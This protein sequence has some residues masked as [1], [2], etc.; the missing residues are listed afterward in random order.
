[1]TFHRSQIEDSESKFDAECN[2]TIKKDEKCGESGQKC[3]LWMNFEARNVLLG[4]LDTKMGS[5]TQRMV[6]DKTKST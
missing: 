5:G 2:E 3:T 6:P 1:V 4:K